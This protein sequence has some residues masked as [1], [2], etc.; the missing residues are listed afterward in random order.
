MSHTH[1]LM[2]NGQEQHIFGRSFNFFFVAFCNTNTQKITEIYLY[3]THTYLSQ[4]NGNPILFSIKS[5]L[6]CI[7]QFQRFIAAVVVVVVVERVFQ[8]IKLFI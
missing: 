4:G 1:T 2:V 7:Q 6:N 3:E 5:N 8:I